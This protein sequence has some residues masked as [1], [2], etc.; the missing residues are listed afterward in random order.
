MACRS[1]ER[2][3]QR[4]SSSAKAG[5]ATSVPGLQEPYEPPHAPDLVVRGENSEE[6]VRRIVKILVAKRYLRQNTPPEAPAIS[7]LI[8]LP[9]R[10]TRRLRQKELVRSDIRRIH[11]HVEHK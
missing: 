6:D 5:Q 2:Y 1:C 9:H 4:T 8:E 7:C 10:S 11:F 3:S